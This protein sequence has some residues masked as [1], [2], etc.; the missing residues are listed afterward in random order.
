[1]NIV[2]WLWCVYVHP[3]VLLPSYC[4]ESDFAVITRDFED[5]VDDKVLEAVKKATVAA[6]TAAP[7]GTPA[8]SEGAK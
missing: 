2:N 4:S 3:I 8:T 5:Y 6:A 1:M 7:A